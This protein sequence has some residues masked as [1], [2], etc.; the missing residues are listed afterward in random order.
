[1]SKYP[2]RVIVCRFDSTSHLRG[3]QR[4][5]ENIK[6]AV[7]DAGQFSEFDIQTDKDARMFTKLCHDDP[8]IEII[9][10]GYPWTGVRR[11]KP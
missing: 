8:E 11:V 2:T 1:M 3:R 6:A 7:L 9:K 10:L 5:Y 4:T